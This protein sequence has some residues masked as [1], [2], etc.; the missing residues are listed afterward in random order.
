MS[1]VLVTGGAGFIGR[2]VV[3]ALL[4]A[5]HD[6]VAADLEPCPVPG[7]TAVVGDLLDGA[8]ASRCVGAGLD[9]VVH[10]AAATS[11]LGSVERPAAVHRTNVELTAG[12]LELAR[13]R[14]VP[15]FV[16]I[17]TNAVV[18]DV[19][20]DTIVES[21]PLAPLTPYGGTKA[22][23]EMLLSGYAGS[24]GLRAPVLRLTNVYGPGMQAKDSLVPRLLR[25][26]ADG[27]EIEVYGDGEQ[28]RD[29]VHVGDVAQ[30]VAMAVHRWPTG[31][32]IVGGARSYRV[33]ELLA[34]A[35]EA[36][37]RDLRSRH[38][39]PKPGEMPAVVVDI[40]RARSLGF[41]PSTSLADGLR[42]AWADFAPS[43]TATT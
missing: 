41:R 35:R 24:F 28:R 42:Q 15:A 21:L 7:A 2:H 18:G 9:A 10:L 37:G 5:G 38:V 34:A 8:V 33:N 27:S 12:L 14:E 39:A 32:V 31:P 25:A 13:L 16:F 30:A 1:R 40:A 4:D 22:A 20:T 6:V 26:A 43:S 19:G 3:R 17:S 29:L 11:V 23:C 36:T